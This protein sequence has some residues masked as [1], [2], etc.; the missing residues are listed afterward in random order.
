MFW[1]CEMWSPCRR[2]GKILKLRGSITMQD[3]DLG[4]WSFA[5]TFRVY[6]VLKGNKIS[7]LNP[8]FIKSNG[9]NQVLKL[10]LWTLEAEYHS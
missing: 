1:G 7:T 9:E 3:V 4:F 10:F 2:N 6:I 5:I 8:A